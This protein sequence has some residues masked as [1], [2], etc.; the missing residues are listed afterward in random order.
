MDVSVDKRGV[1]PTSPF[2]SSNKR[3]TEPDI[4]TVMAFEVQFSEDGVAYE[5][6]SFR[7]TDGNWY[8]TG[9]SKPMP[10]DWTRLF[11]WLRCHK[12]ATVKFA[13]AWTDVEIGGSS[14]PGRDAGP[15]DDFDE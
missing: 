2:G 9:T 3:L 4:G 12:V 11:S 7:S 8:T 1:T 10:R 14:E 15:D 6:V 5:Y 13:T